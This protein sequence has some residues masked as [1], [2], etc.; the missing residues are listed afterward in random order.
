MSRHHGPIVVLIVIALVGGLIYVAEKTKAPAMVPSEPL[1]GAILIAQQKNKMPF[2]ESL[3]SAMPKAQAA[4]SAS[5]FDMPQILI[6]QVV[7]RLSER[8]NDWAAFEKQTRAQVASLSYNDLMALAGK[9]LDTEMAVRERDVAVYLLSLA[10]MPAHNALFEVVKTPVG[11]KAHVRGK[12]LQQ[13]DDDSVKMRALVALD[14]LAVLNP[15]QLYKTMN[16]IRKSKASSSIKSSAMASLV[17]I[18]KGSP[19]KLVVN[20]NQTV[21]SAEAQ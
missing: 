11:N 4:K 3:K 7:Q 6:D 10:G 21:A 14:Q 16:L 2:S 8:R 1:P 20:L 19:G 13:S 18:S 9:A 5:V 17:G 12:S 15:N